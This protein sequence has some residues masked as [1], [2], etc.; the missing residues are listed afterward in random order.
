MIASNLL[1]N[2]IGRRINSD[3][4]VSTNGNSTVPTLDTP[5]PIMMRCARCSSSMRLYSVTDGLKSWTEY[6]CAECDYAVTA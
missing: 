3:S 2:L 5:L 6:Y 1:L 4:V